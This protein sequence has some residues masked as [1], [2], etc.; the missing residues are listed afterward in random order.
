MEE[1]GRFLITY[2]VW[3][4]EGIGAAVVI[5]LLAALHRMKRIERRVR[6][7]NEMLQEHLEKMLAELSKKEK[8]ASE[9]RMMQEKESE[10]QRQEREKRGQVSLIRDVLE[11]VFP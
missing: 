4:Y 8:A 1:I 11:E 6:V 2:S 9:Q 3:V 5:L 7:Q 10:E